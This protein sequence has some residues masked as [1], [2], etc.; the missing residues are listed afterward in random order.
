MVCAE[1]GL[2]DSHVRA[3]CH[4]C[5]SSHVSSQTGA[6]PKASHWLPASFGSGGQGAPSEALTKLSARGSEPSIPQVH[7]LQMRG[8]YG[9][10]CSSQSYLVWKLHIETHL[11]LSNV[12]EQLIWESIKRIDTERSA[13]RPLQEGCMLMAKSISSLPFS[14]TNLCLF[15]KYKS[16][17]DCY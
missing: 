7:C 13:V 16:S 5:S 15:L 1:N 4:C 12:W 8:C 14:L 3:T 10:M 17:I 6:Q 9:S 2:D 11:L